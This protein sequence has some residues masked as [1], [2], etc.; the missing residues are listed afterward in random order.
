MA[1]DNRGSK[2]K[3]TGDRQRRGRRDTDRVVR[4]LQA[5]AV[6][7]GVG[8][9][10][11]SGQ[12]VA[13]ATTEGSADTATSGA[14]AG[15]TTN[16][17]PS[18]GAD[19][20]SDGDPTENEVEQTDSESTDTVPEDSEEAEPD[21]DAEQEDEKD[22]ELDPPV[23]VEDDDSKPLADNA[24]RRARDDSDLAPKVTNRIA[25]TQSSFTATEIATAKKEEASPAATTFAINT[26]EAS[27]VILRPPTATV[28]VTNVGPPQIPQWRPLRGLVLGVLGAFGYTPGA[29]SPNP[30]LEA[31]WGLYRR[32]ESTFANQRPN[33]NGATVVNSELTDQGQ[34]IITGAVDFDDP[35]G[36]RMLYESTNGAHGTVVVNNDG[37]FT[38]TPT[39]PE[40]T[41][42]DSFTITASDAGRHLHGLIGLITPRGGHI[43]TATISINLTAATNDAPVINHVTSDPG[44]GNSWTVTVDATDPDDDPLT[45]TLTAVDAD[46]VTITPV[47][48]SPNKFTVT[49]TDTAW[50]LANPGKQLT[51]TATAT[52][53]LAT[54]AP[55]TEAIGTV[56]NVV[57]LGISVPALPAGLTY[58]KF[59]ADD[60]SILLIRSD[61]TVVALGSNSSG[62][63][64]IPPQNEGVIYTDVASGGAH[65]VLLRA[66]GTAFTV[67]WNQYGQLTMPTLAPGVTIKQVAAGY[68]SSLYLLSD[69]TV[70]AYGLWTEGLATL[71]PL[72]AGVTYKQISAGDVSFFL[73]R[74]DGRVDSFGYNSF[75]RTVVPPLPAG[76]T[77]T[78]VGAGVNHTLFLLSDGSVATNGNNAYG[79]RNIPPLAPGIKYTQV[80]GGL[81]H[82]VLL[83]SDG[84]AIA[85]STQNG[86]GQLNIPTLP[87]GIVYTQIGAGDEL[88]LL[89]IDYA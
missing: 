30:L 26:V 42:T 18:N 25:E 65:S 84:T 47:D 34:V 33:V 2:N 71:P 11:I 5:G 8:A 13:W 38:Y 54:S 49:I 21:E 16:T 9:A 79:Q 83:R 36:D 45:V 55:D 48:G 60:D 89:M 43:R 77:Y 32:V 63:L 85:V 6:A 40:F 61:G 59:S 88:T 4:W 31:V 23:D 35:D 52:D 62:Q 29:P 56:T 41:G 44:I 3:R 7:T 86:S 72:P 68:G 28:A 76:L 57:G 58:T 19:T 69:G 24:S 80:A 20:P 50:A 12:G 82:S 87:E 1:A 78:Q 22:E 51:V 66:D 15:D 39:D 17:T 74:T 37:T 64:N 27:A 73:L 53:G 81:F 14:D 67:G 75:G 46:R 70:A 10:V